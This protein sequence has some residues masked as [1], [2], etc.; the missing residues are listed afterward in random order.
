MQSSKT[1]KTIK[2]FG[3]RSNKITLIEITFFFRIIADEILASPLKNEV[4]FKKISVI[5]FQRF[6][7]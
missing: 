3:K 7:K 4:L 2:V 6:T 1:I 5:K